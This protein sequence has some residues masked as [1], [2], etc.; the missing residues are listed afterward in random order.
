MILGYNDSPDDNQ[1]SKLFSVLGLVFASAAWCSS[2]KAIYARELA[3]PIAVC[4][5]I[6]THLPCSFETH[7]LHKNHKNVRSAQP[8]HLL[9]CV[10]AS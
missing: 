1:P 3:T 10:P 8:S 2:P 5:D 7:D 6:S 9:P 4:N